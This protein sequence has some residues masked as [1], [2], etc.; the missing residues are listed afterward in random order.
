MSR[1]DEARKALKELEEKHE[2]RVRTPEIDRQT[3]NDA[4]DD[5]KFNNKNHAP[6]PH[7]D[8]PNIDEKWHKDKNGNWTHPDFEE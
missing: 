4:L 7:K 3:K 8:D 5:P 1:R 2:H 6:K